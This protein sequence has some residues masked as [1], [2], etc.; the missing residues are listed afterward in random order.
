MR[1]SESVRRVF[2]KKRIQSKSLA[3]PRGHFAAHGVESIPGRL[4]S[5]I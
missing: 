2:G 1:H 3:K 4:P 5:S